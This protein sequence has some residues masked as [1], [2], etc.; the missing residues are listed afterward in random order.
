MQGVA[1]SLRRAAPNLAESIEN[2]PARPYATAPAE[3]RL[4]SAC[5]SPR[6]KFESTVL[7]GLQK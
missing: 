5:G 3:P 2:Y 6:K 1:I 7:A 4:S